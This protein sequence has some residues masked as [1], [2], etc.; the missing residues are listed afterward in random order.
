MTTYRGPAELGLARRVLLS[1]TLPLERIVTFPV[2]ETRRLWRDYVGLVDVREH[3]EELRQR[4]TGLELENLQY[5]E[6]I[7]SSDLLE[8][9]TPEL[10]DVVRLET[11][12]L[13]Y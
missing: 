2:R 8:V 12:A 4:I 6:A 1:I 13:H 9:S 7:V 3:N 10:D 11:I 5:R